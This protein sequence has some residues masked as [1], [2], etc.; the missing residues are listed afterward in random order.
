MISCVKNWNF[1]HLFLC[2]FCCL[3]TSVSTHKRSFKI[4]VTL[5]LSMEMK[6]QNKQN[7]V[8][9]LHAKWNDPRITFSTSAWFFFSKINNMIAY[10][11]NVPRNTHLCIIAKPSANP[12]NLAHRQ[13]NPFNPVITKVKWKLNQK[14]KTNYFQFLC[15]HLLPPLDINA[16][17]KWT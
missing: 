3:E 16:E 15:F 1:N 14:V 9:T 6:V 8:A 12:A 4:H 11:R 2:F 7:A 13:L 5:Q 17:V 10:C